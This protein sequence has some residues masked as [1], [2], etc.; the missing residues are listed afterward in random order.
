MGDVV[1]VDFDGSD[2]FRREMDDILE[3]LI[4]CV[5]RHYG[6]YAGELMAKS[7]IIAMEMIAERLTK[8][9]KNN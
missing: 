5:T 3:D 1:K 2:S 7:F 8:Q 6:E 9:L 4:T